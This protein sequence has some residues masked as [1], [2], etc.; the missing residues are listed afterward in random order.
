MNTTVIAKIL[1][2]RFMT[3]SDNCRGLYKNTP[4]AAIEIFDVNRIK[5]TIVSIL[6]SDGV[7][8]VDYLLICWDSKIYVIERNG[9][10]SYCK[11]EVS[12]H[13]L[14]EHVKLTA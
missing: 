9:E 4:P 1:P 8:V 10:K 6:F 11:R 5:E 7:R 2:I 3:Y 14:I 12:Y 13:P